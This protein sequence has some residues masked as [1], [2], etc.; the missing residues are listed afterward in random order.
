MARRRLT[1]QTVSEDSLERLTVLELDPQGSFIDTETRKPVSPLAVKNY[2]R[3]ELAVRQD[4]TDIFVWVHGWRND[5]SAAIHA[6]R[7]MFGGIERLYASQAA[8]YP[9][10]KAFKGQYVVVCWPSH[11]SPLPG[12]YAKIRERAHQMTTQGYAEYC[13]AQLLGYLDEGRDAPPRVPG[14]LQTVSGQYLHCVGHSFGGRFLGQA[15]SAAAT[16][17]APTL[18]LLPPNQKFS[19]T[20]DT[21]LVFQ[22]AARPDIFSTELRSLLTDAPLQ[23]PVCLTFSSADRATCRWH[24]LAEGVAGIGCAGAS[25]PPGDI[26]TTRLHSV[27]QDYQAEELAAKIVNVDAN[28]RYRRGRYIKPAGAHSDIWHDESYHLLLTLMNFAR[29]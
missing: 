10:I 4:V 27:G 19:F 16:P 9:Q 6:A 3:N 11:S 29:P 23:G 22:M 2:L 24:R 28:W 8:H 14:M 12:G 5:R 25:A 15:I 20:V 17:S 1:L 21:F 18:A 13:L 7:K 26:I